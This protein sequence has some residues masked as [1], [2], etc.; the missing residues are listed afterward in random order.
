MTALDILSDGFDRVREGVREV[1]D[2]LTTDQLD[3]RPAED[4]NS[5]AWLLWHTSRVQDAQMAA[6]AGTPEVWTASGWAD[7]FGLDLDPTETGYG[8]TQEQVAAVRGVTSEQLVGYH[9][10]TV[11]RTREILAGMTEADLVRVID[12]SYDPPVTVGVRVLSILADDLEHVGQAVFVRGMVE[13][14]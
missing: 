4:A 6:L 7:R 10:A 14:A 12:E 8:H 1:A 9:E 2:S 5:V 11:E 13:H 3:V